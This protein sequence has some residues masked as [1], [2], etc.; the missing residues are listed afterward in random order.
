MQV[1]QLKKRS[2]SFVVL[3]LVTVTEEANVMLLFY[4][5]LIFYF[6]CSWGSFLMATY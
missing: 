3:Y 2:V 4:H 6:G 5:F 1:N